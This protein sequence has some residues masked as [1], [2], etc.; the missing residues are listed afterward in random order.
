VRTALTT[1]RDELPREVNSPASPFNPMGILS[2]KLSF[3]SIASFHPPR[4]VAIHLWKVF[5]DSV[6]PCTKVTHIPTSETIVYTVASDPSKATAENLGLC[7]AIYYASTTALT[8]E[9]VLDVTGEDKK[10]VLHR[11]RVCL[12]QS[13]ALA[14]FLDNPTMTLV[15]ALAICSVRPAEKSND[16][17]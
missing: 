4:K 13:L 1:P 3:A 10:Q 6:D 15:Q 8:P 2:A 11:Y 7:F 16:Q 12:E 5:V 9:E 17:R 14:D